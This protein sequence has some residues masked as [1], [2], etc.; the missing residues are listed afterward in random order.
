MRA[1]RTIA[2]L[3]VIM[4]VLSAF[5]VRKYLNDTDTKIKSY[6]TDVEKR[7]V[8]RMDKNDVAVLTKVEE[9]KQKLM[10][11]DIVLARAILTVAQIQQEQQPMDIAKARTSV[12]VIYDER[13]LGSGTIFKQKDGDMYILTCAH[14]VADSW[15]LVKN[16]EKEVCTAGYYLDDKVEEGTE[17]K[18]PAKIMKFDEE[19]DLAVIKITTDDVRMTVSPVANND[20]QVGDDIWVIGNPLGVYRNVAKGILSNKVASKNFYNVDCLLT[21]GNS[22]GAVFNRKGE[23]IG[24]PSRVP[25][26]EATN[27]LGLQILVPETNLGSIVSYPVVKAFVK[28]FE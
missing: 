5:A 10:L 16:G 20:P 26:F 7:I 3:T 24:V 11:N 8:L 13:G 28:E 15:E 25:M 22:G 14:V 17:I 2:V 6:I 4:V 21:F 12:V 1:T 9:A 18:Y 19:L 23:L 27:E